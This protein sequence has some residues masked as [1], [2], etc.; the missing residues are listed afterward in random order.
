MWWPSVNNGDFTVTSGYHEVW[1]SNQVAFHGPSGSTGIEQELWGWIWSANIPQKVKMFLWKGCQNCL[2]VKENLC[3]KRIANSSLC[4]VCKTETETIEHS[5]LLCEW[6]RPVWLG[7]QL[8]IIPNGAEITSFHKWLYNMLKQFRQNPVN[9]EFATTS[10]CSYLWFIWKQRNKVCFDGFSPN[11]MATILQSNSFI[12]DLLK[13][14]DQNRHPLNA[15]P[16][17]TLQQHNLWRPPRGEVIKINSDAGFIAQKNIGSAGIIARNYEG[18]VVFGI[19]KK[20]P[21][22]SPL[23]AEALALREAAAVAVNFG[24]NKV[25]LESDCLDLIRCCRREIRKG[26]IL[27]VVEDTIGYANCLPECGF[28]WVPKEGNRVAHT[29]AQLTIRGSLPL[30]WRWYHPPVLQVALLHDKM[31]ISQATR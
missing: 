23:M 14:S 20:F 30:H 16:R 3:K 5:L 21:A 12:A 19:T 29:L 13:I 9:Q 22:T 27:N 1:K 8:Q 18:V 10:L 28:L 25:V 6:I 4:P 17:S 7:T 26:E 15:S 2:P 11:L 31:G 24:L